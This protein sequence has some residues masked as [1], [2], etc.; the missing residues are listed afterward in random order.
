MNKRKN[1]CRNARV[2]ALAVLL[3]CLCFAAQAQATGVVSGRYLTRTSTELTLEIKVESPVP[4]TLIII[5]H[6]PP[7]TTPATASPSYKKYNEKKGE[8]RWLFRNVQTGTL[9]I[10]LTL[11]TPVKP[12]QVHAEIRC[13]DP[14]TGT[15]VT[16][17]VN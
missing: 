15:L 10:N 11:M 5:Q 12:D 7:G 3:P 16:T 2:I 13:M 8:V 9:K 4:V 17:L 14:V 1:Y 6:L